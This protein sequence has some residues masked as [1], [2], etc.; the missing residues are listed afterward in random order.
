MVKVRSLESV[1][2]SRYFCF[3]NVLRICNIQAIPT[4]RVYRLYILDCQPYH[5]QILIELIELFVCTDL[6]KQK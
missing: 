3:S 5:F 4:Y 2:F 6:A 1:L